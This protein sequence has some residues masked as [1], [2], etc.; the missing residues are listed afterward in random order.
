MCGAVHARTTQLVSPA[1]IATR[2][3]W[4]RSEAGDGSV[5]A[6]TPNIAPLCPLDLQ[7]VPNPV[8][9]GSGESAASRRLP[10]N[11][12]SRA[13]SAWLRR[14]RRRSHWPSEDPVV[15]SRVATHRREGIWDRSASVPG[16]WVS[17]SIALR[18]SNGR[19]TGRAPGC[20]WGLNAGGSAVTDVRDVDA[21]HGVCEMR[22]NAHG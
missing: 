17:M 4:W 5:I 19:L 18:R 1:T 7:N 20:A 3:S 21:G 2:Q 10:G 6:T 11:R 16:F 12:H 14:R 13:P 22:S 8:L 15:F 9:A